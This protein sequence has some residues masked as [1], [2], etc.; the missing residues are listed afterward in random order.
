MDTD[1]P[2][3]VEIADKTFD[4]LARDADMCVAPASIDLGITIDVIIGNIESAYVSYLL[5]DDHD[6]AMVAKH[7]TEIRTSPGVEDLHIDALLTQA[8]E[9]RAVIAI[10][11]LMILVSINH[12]P[13]LHPTTGSIEQMP[14]GALSDAVVGKNE[15]LDVNRCLR[16]ADISKE[17][18]ELVSAIGIDIDA[19]K[20]IFLQ[21]L[22]LQILEQ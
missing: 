18:I 15:I 1:V 5:V 16:L 17:R 19:V 12:E 7:M 4:C 22:H 9:S 2:C 10:A 21:S 8:V 11:S 13:H 3:I 6:L 20:R 14:Y